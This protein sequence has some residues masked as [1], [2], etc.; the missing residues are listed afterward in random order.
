[1]T[2]CKTDIM[3]HLLPILVLLLSS[4]ATVHKVQESHA[5]KTDSATHEQTAST[6]ATHIQEWADKVAW[7]DADTI[8]TTFDTTGGDFETDDQIVRVEQLPGNRRLKITAIAKPKAVHVQ[9]SKTTDIKEAVKS[10][11]DTRVKSNETVTVKNKDKKPDMIGNSLTIVIVLVVL[12]GLVWLFLKLKK[13][14]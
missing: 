14:Y 8:E 9:V 2:I 13:M 12:A 1:M 10:N 11:V 7:S 4:C 3:K 6:T 5:T